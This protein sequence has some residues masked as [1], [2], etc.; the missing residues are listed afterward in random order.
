MENIKIVANSEDA[1]NQ[2]VEFIKLNVPDILNCNPYTDIFIVAR[3]KNHLLKSG[4]YQ[5]SKNSR[6]NITDSAV[7]N[8]ILRAQG[9][10]LK[11]NFTNR[12]ENR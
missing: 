9:K 7:I 3:A 11:R 5:K 1:I 8:Y 2:R 12:K 6:P 4:L 10:S